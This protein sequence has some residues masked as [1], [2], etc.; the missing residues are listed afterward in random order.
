MS[1][2]LV[3]AFAFGF[4]NALPLNA[5]ALDA[6]PPAKPK[7]T[8]QTAAK[9]PNTATLRPVAIRLEGTL[10]LLSYYSVGITAGYAFHRMFALEGTAAWEGGFTHGI[11]GRLRTPV[12]SWS[13][14]SVGIGATIHWVPW[15]GEYNWPGVYVWLP[16]EIGWEYRTKDGH[17]FLVGAGARVL[18]YANQEIPDFPLCI[19]CLTDPP[20]VYPS[21][22]IGIGL[23]F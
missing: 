18:T 9:E 8:Q 1:K 13:S 10:S 19:L 17:H 2:R 20:K 21:A 15:K 3:M 11:M 14:I 7:A 6:E 4:I 5:F 23:A 12:A 16:G 22:R